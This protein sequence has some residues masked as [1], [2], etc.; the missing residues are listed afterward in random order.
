[1]C[2]A[3][4]MN[5]DCYSGLNRTFSLCSPKDAVATKKVSADTSALDVLTQKLNALQVS[6]IKCLHCAPSLMQCVDLQVSNGQEVL[7]L[8]TRSQRIFSDISTHFQYRLPNC[9]SAK[10]N[11]ILREWVP[12]MPQDHEFRCFVHNRRLSTLVGCALRVCVV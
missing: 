1:M 8:L 9:S 3:H 4:R 12:D 11:L 6:T 10:L 2:S 7:E 5:R